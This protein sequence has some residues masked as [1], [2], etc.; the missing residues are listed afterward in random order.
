MDNVTLSQNSISSL[1]TVVVWD[2]CGS[3]TAWINYRVYIARWRTYS[4]SGIGFASH[5]SNLSNMWTSLSKLQVCCQLLLHNYKKINK[6]NKPNEAEW[7]IIW[8][9]IYADCNICNRTDLIFEDRTSLTW[10]SIC[11]KTYRGVT[12][13]SI[14]NMSHSVLNWVR[15]IKVFGRA[16]CNQGGVFLISLM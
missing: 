4:N 3:S 12:L 9:V 5:R 11:S 6:W 1:P 10:R 15:C 13:C 7:P 8:C 16:I 2:V 14:C